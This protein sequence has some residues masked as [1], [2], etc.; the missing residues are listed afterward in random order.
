MSG[1]RSAAPAMR[2]GARA[3]HARG[4]AIAPASWVVSLLAG[5]GQGLPSLRR[6]P[7]HPLDAFDG[8]Q[9]RSIRSCMLQMHCLSPSGAA[10]EPKKSCRRTFAANRHVVGRLGNPGIGLD[11][12]SREFI[13]KIFPQRGYG[14]ASFSTG[15]GPPV[16]PG[17]MMVGPA[18][19]PTSEVPPVGSGSEGRQKWGGENIG[20][21]HLLSG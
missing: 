13:G 5:R 18:A 14:A 9:R 4:S 20:T 3:R 7:Y 2:S 21:A 10:L 11:M 15:T 17:E 8:C 12:G 19:P 1:N 6:S 16:P